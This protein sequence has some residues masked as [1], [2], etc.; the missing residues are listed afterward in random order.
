LIEATSGA[1][2]WADR[3]DG[4]LEDV[5][6]LQDQVAASVVGA[7]APSLTQAEIERAKRKPTNSLDAYDYYLRGLAAL[8]QRTRDATDQAVGFYE[9][10]IAR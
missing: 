1:H 3:Y 9:Q 8:W 10:A 2:L 6:E 5:F 4:A 7:I